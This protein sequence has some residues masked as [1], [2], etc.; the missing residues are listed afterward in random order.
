MKV[1]NYKQYIMYIHKVRLHAVLELAENEETYKLN[2]KENELDKFIKGILNDKNEIKILINNYLN[3]KRKI[4]MEELEIYNNNYITKKYGTLENNVIYKIKNEKVFFIIEHNKNPNNKI[5]YRMLNICV[6][7]MQEWG[8][9]KSIKQ[10]TS[11]PLVIPIIVYTGDDK[12]K[13]P[14]DFREK[15]VDDYISEKSNIELEYNLIDTNKITKDIIINNPS[16]L[17]YATLIKKSQSLEELMEN[18]NIIMDLEKDKNKIKKVKKF[19]I[20]YI[21][22]FYDV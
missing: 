10:K 12:W 4:K 22:K 2:T 14:R 7:I 3:S 18:L 20:N 6:D 11:Y 21:K 1:F 16:M 9:N 17:G 5:P 8:K 15:Q 19:A 13:V